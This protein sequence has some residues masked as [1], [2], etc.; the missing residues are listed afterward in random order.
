[1]KLLWLPEAKADLRRAYDFLVARDH[2]AA[3]RAIRS[4]REAAVVLRKHPEMGRPLG[5]S[6]RRRELFVRFGA[7]AHVLRYRLDRDAIV[8]LRVWHS[9]QQR[10]E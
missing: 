6:L 1:M 7:G 9:R 5:D 4:I 10:G 8:I 2:R 3:M